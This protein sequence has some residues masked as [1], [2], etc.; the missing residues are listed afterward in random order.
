MKKIILLAVFIIQASL[1]VCGAGQAERPNRYDKFLFGVDYYPEHWD[2]RL[3][4]QDARRMRECGV[5]VVRMAEFAWALM[6]PEEGRFDFSLFDRAMAVFARHGIKVILGTPTATPPKWLT[7]KYPEV[8]H[9]FP[10]GRAADDQSRRHYCYNSPTYRRLSRRIV[11]RMAEHYRAR[12]EVIGWQIDN[13]FNNENP[14]CYSES[15]R[16]AFRGWLKSKY[17]TL[18]SLN[19]RWGTVFWSQLYTDWEQVD[20]PSQTPAFHNPAL[21]LDFKRFISDSVT[22]YMEEQVSIIR[23]HRPADFV[24]QNGVFRNINYYR[25]SRGLDLHSNANYPLFVDD[26]QYPIG[27]ALTLSR[28]FTGRFLI[29]EQQT[30]PAGQTYLLRVPRPGEMS[31]W[32][33]QSI[34]HGADGIV[35]FR[36]RAA[37]RGAE[38]YWYGVLDHD[39]VPRARY[40]EFRKEG[41]EIN[42]VGAEVLG[43]K[44]VSDIAVV[45][46]FEAEW[47]Y[48]HQ[49]F[50]REVNPRAALGH[51][52]RAA[53]EL[54]YNIDFISPEADFG[55]YKIIFAPHLLM[56]TPELS[57]RIKEFV[58]GGGTFVMGAHGAV[59]DRDNAM[60]DQTIPIEG[61]TALFGVEVESFQVY[62]PPSAGKNSLRFGAGGVAA[63]VNVFADVLKPRGAEVVAVWER[64][65]MRGRPAVTENRS[66]RGKAVY[67]GSFFNLESAR[68]LVGRYA[69]E[70]NLKPLFEGFPAG[71]EVTRRTKGRSNYYFILN[72]SEESVTVSP[73]A[74]YFDLIAG[75]ESAP[76]LTLKPFEYR[77]LKR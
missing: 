31:L 72:H 24:T 1:C 19:D 67:Y 20:L 8:L 47:A 33:F 32:A 29:M 28:S 26:P 63:P 45:Q 16:V 2:E 42:R 58:A 55:A 52:F 7:H 11:E 53:S 21:V 14:E 5:R 23:K 18:K 61:L 43:S 49:Y 65:F 59:K 54:K 40:E 6:E 22:S 76:A 60:T 56:M 25:L 27:A 37:R 71:V 4:E 77:V 66:G 44:V 36:W 17:G 51:F 9:V 69:A 48:E 64:D 15:C 10:N 57:A 13:E 3:W 41:A 38:E 68:H 62:Q 34:A 75:R 74:G 30:G 39:D 12:P 46:D 73:G 35:H 70:H 50:T